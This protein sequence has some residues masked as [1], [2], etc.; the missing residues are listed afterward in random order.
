MFGKLTCWLAVG[1]FG[2]LY[3]E[4]QVLPGWRLLVTTVYPSSKEAKLK[5]SQVERNCM[6]QVVKD[7]LTVT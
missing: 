3:L 6:L 1:V 4:F 5:G 7:M 2:E